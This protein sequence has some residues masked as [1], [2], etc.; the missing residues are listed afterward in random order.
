MAYQPLLKPYANPAHR[1]II[2][3]TCGLD[4][5]SASLSSKGK[6]NS[7]PTL[8]E[9]VAKMEQDFTRFKADAT[10]AYQ[11]MAMQVTLT[12]ALAENTIKR[13][14]MMHKEMSHRFA[15]I[16]HALTVHFD[17]TNAHF[18]LLQKHADKTDK[19]LDA[20]ETYTG[21]TDKRLDT[22]ETRLDRVE[23]VLTEHTAVLNE[24]TTRLDRVEGVLAEHTTRF[25]RVEGVLA[26]ILT[27]LPE[28]A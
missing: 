26:E 7:M 1:V 2:G 22:I 24:H 16:D 20:I 21:K 6:V 3:L 9:R 23:G 10:E 19:R 11:E 8:E 14:D 5:E 25:D 18:D 17:A 4:A 27:R 13:V 28:K 15:G 12:K